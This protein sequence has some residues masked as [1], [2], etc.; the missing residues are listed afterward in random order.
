MWAFWSGIK[1][2]STLIIVVESGINCVGILL[3]IIADWIR[4]KNKKANLYLMSNRW[5]REKQIS[6][7]VTI[8]EI[9]KMNANR[10]VIIL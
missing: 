3:A 4:K 7:G 2:V 10:E 8:Y 9:S 1:E 6:K 5:E